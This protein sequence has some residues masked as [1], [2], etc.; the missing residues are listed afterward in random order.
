MI[1]NKDLE[2]Q[3][4]YFKDEMT[5]AYENND[6]WEYL[7]NLDIYNIDFTIT[8]CYQVLKYKS[9]CIMV[10]CGGPNIY[11]DTSNG[12]LIGAW[13]GDREKIYLDNNI[14]NEINSYFEDYYDNFK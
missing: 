11:I 4:E 14:I 1:N 8:L 12:A 13:G 3:L 9:V 6:F 5:E 7:A 2:I 10:A